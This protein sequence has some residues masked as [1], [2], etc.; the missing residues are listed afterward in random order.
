M[1]IYIMRALNITFTDALL[2]AI[3]A[4]APRVYT[5]Q[6]LARK[7]SKGYAPRSVAGGVDTM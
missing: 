7:Q 4:M 1:Y 2:A 6:T 3:K 5:P